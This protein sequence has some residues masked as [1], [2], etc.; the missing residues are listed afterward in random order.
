MFQGS[1]VFIDLVHITTV[2]SWK[3]VMSGGMESKM[4]TVRVDSQNCHTPKATSQTEDV[5]TDIESVEGVTGKTPVDVTI[6]T[7]TFLGVY[8]VCV[9]FQENKKR[10]RPRK[11]RCHD[12]TMMTTK[13]NESLK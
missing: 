7:K 1:S 3:G 4:T 8:R 11:G 2:L 9:Y 10:R 12:K 5:L 13:T 6:C